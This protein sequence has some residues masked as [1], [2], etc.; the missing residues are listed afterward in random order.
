[1]LPLW[2]DILVLLA[3]PAILLTVLKLMG[4]NEPDNTVAHHQEGEPP[5]SGDEDGQL[6]ITA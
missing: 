4:D 6:L 2:A 5:D 1:M 3:I